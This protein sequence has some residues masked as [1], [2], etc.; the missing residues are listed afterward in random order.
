MQFLI[1]GPTVSFGPDAKRADNQ[2]AQAKNNNNDLKLNVIVIFNDMLF[3]HNM[4]RE[5]SK[6]EIEWSPWLIYF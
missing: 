3:Y 5:F 1:I 6:I 4:L 2:T